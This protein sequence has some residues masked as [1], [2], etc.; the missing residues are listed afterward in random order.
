M[1]LL[2]EDTQW[3]DDA[4]RSGIYPFALGGLEFVYFAKHRKYEV[5]IFQ[6]IIA[7]YYQ[8]GLQPLTWGRPLEASTCNGSFDI[9]AVQELNVEEYSWKYTLEHSK[10]ALGLER[11]LVCVGDLNRMDS[12]KRRGGGFFCL[13]DAALHSAYSS[14]IKSVEPCP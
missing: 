1:T 12:Q 3:S 13:E 11:P 7:P 6:D 4:A 2:V 14:L 8:S 5:D 10:W 9:E